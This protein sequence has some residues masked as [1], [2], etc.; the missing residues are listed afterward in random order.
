MRKRLT[1]DLSSFRRVF[2][3]SVCAMVASPSLPRPNKLTYE[4]TAAIP[5]LRPT[6]CARY[7]ALCDFGVGYAYLLHTYTP[8]AHKYGKR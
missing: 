7:H 5:H 4:L 2:V 1:F 6:P 8:T 3:S